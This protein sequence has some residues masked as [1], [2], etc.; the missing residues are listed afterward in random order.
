MDKMNETTRKMV[1]IEES[2][3][4]TIK[5]LQFNISELYDV[6][7]KESD[8][9]LLFN[10]YKQVEEREDL[11]D[12][13]LKILI[14]LEQCRQAIMTK[15]RPEEPKVIIKQNEITIENVVTKIIRN[16]GIPANIKGYDYT[17]EAIIFLMKEE[18]CSITK[19]LY[20]TIARKFLTSSSRVERAIRHAIEKCYTVGNMEALE[21]YVGNLYGDRNKPTNSQ[22]MMEIVKYIKFHYPKIC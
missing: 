15:T 11:E 14:M 6:E 21:K 18:N 3:M 10:I 13:T 19:I 5:Q 1:D 20:P 2:I 4:S 8:V 17:R 16:I 22:F 7:F 12:L 9:Q